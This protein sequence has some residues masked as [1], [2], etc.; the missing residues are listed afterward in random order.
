MNF[1]NFD[2]LIKKNSYMP[3]KAMAHSKQVLFRFASSILPTVEKISK[4]S[5]FS[6]EKS[7]AERD[8]SA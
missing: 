3:C 7:V 8:L 6:F 4:I 2:V 5:S 1:H